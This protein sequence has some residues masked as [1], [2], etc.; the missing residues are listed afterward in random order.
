[1]D[2]ISASPTSGFGANSVFAHVVRAL[3]VLTVVRKAE[4]ILVNDS[5]RVKE[6]LLI[7]GLADFNKLSAKLILGADSPA[8]QENRVTTVHCLSSTGSLRVG[9]ESKCVELLATGVCIE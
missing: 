2:S 4:Q 8:I 9:V 5:S 1:M 7:V 3:L 6:Y